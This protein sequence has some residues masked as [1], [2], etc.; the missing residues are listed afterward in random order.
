MDYNENMLKDKAA[1]KTRRTRRGGAKATAETT[2]P[3]EAPKAEVAE[4]P[5]AAEAPAQE[6]EKAE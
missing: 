5:V 4:E 6:A 2:K 3:E 1:K